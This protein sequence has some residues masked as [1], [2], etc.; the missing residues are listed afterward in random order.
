[1]SDQ[2]GWCYVM[3]HPAW[4][5]I[6]MVKV[7]MTARDPSRRAAEICS[8]SGLIA[9]AQVA[10]CLWVED[11]RAVELAVK[12]ALGGNRVRGRRELF[13]TDVATARA[14]IESASCRKSPV[15]I[16]HRPFR[17]RSSARPSRRGRI[18]WWRWRRPL[19]AIVSIPLLIWL[20]GALL[21]P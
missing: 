20:I 12:D 2:A 9:P 6:G 3:V 13:R 5:K 4:T 16:R 1:M 8:S 18:I 7:G 17:S 10:F 14:A 15:V 19:A 11:R 21:H